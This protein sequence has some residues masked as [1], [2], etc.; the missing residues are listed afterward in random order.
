[1]VVDALLEANP[2]FKFHEN[3]F[4]PSV[5][6]NYTDNILNLIESSNKPELQVS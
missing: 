3:L 4:N 6:V 2:V 1:M 5:Y